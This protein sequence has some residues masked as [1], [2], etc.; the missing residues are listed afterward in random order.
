MIKYYNVEH[1][2][3][4]F[5]SYDYYSL[6]K[7][8][9]NKE[10]IYNFITWGN[11]HSTIDCG[12]GSP[13]SSA[14]LHLFKN[15]N[16]FK[17]KKQEVKIIAFKKF[18]CDVFIFYF[19]DDSLQMLHK[20]RGPAFVECFIDKDFVIRECYFK[21]G[22]QHR[23]NG[24]QE[25]RYYSNKCINYE[26]YRQ[27]DVF[28]NEKGPAYILYYYNKN[29]TNKYPHIKLFTIHDSI[30]FQKKYRTEVELIFNNYLKNEL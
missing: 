8:I 12:F 3:K 20:D 10:I 26:C 2:Y 13:V 1:S 19:K 14:N 28:H 21:N 27:N 18:S 23:M 9:T 17:N 15:F 16:F 4:L 11:K 5:A 30:V 29:S 22:M 25:I 7:G 6:E 24:P